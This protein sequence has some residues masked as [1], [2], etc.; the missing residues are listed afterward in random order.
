MRTGIVITLSASDRR[1]VEALVRDRNAPQ[2][3]VWP[4]LIVL[5]SRL[6][7]SYPI[8]STCTCLRER[9]LMA[10]VNHLVSYLE[11]IR[12][13]LLLTSERV[14]E[15]AEAH[16]SGLKTERAPPNPEVLPEQRLRTR[17]RERSR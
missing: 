11:R 5:L 8:P 13:T 6:A 4:A 9:R 14:P 3:H 1:K 16:D 12:D 10:G 2:K 17:R 7:S 15:H